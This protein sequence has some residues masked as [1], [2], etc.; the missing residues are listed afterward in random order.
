MEDESR[1]AAIWTTTETR[2]ELQQIKLDENLPSL[3]SVVKLTI[4]SYKNGKKKRA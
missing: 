2:K 1:P 4:K 3:D